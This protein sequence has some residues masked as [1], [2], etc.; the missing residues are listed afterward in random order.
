MI[1]KIYKEIVS[2]RK[3]LQTM[4]K[5]LEFNFSKENHAEN[6]I[7]GVRQAASSAIHGIDAK[8]KTKQ[9]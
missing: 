3:E 6:I 5:C 9:M 2:I 1:N 8:D 7:D 4:R